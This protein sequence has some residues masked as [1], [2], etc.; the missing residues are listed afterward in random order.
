MV[1][2]VHA[3]LY[4]RAFMEAAAAGGAP[5]GVSLTSDQPPFLCFESIRFWRYTAAFHDE[6]IARLADL[7]TRLVNPLLMLVMGVLIG[8]IV[9]L[10]YLPI[11]KLMEQVQ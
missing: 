7:V 4:P 5:Y 2:D 1:V 8:G 11:F 9:V 6:E 3:H 10:M